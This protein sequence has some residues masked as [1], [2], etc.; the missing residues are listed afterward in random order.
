MNVLLQQSEKVGKTAHNFSEQL[1]RGK[2]K[3]SKQE[4]GT[5]KAELQSIWHTCN[6]G[7]ETGTSW[8]RCTTQ[9]GAHSPCC[10]HLYYLKMIRTRE[11]LQLENNCWPNETNCSKAWAAHFLFAVPL[12]AE[13]HTSQSIRL[14]VWPPPSGNSP[15][16]SRRL[17]ECHSQKR[18]RSK[19]CPCRHRQMLGRLTLLQNHSSR[20]YCATEKL[21]LAEQ[22]T[23]RSLGKA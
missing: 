21:I 14:A 19:A 3:A 4:N 17:E 20:H 18:D 6:E 16:S 1:A 23:N 22:S 7:T 12:H 13:H 8:H 2:K 9:R 15:Q 11:Q 5:F 10:Q